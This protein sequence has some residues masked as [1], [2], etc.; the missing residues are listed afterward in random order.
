MDWRW[1]IREREQLRIT[2]RVFTHVAGSWSC[3]LLKEEQVERGERKQ[4]VLWMG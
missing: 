4:E 2:P 1:D 3:N